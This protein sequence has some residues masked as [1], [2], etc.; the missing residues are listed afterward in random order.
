MGCFSFFR[1]LSAHTFGTSRSAF[2]LV[3]VRVPIYKDYYTSLVD[4]PSYRS[5]LIKKVGAKRFETRKHSPLCTKNC[6]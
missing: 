1:I 6:L 2:S 4:L 5:R 3:F